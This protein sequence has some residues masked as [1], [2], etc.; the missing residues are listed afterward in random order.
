VNCT[1]V[2]ASRVLATVGTTPQ[3]VVR[4]ISDET[5]VVWIGGGKDWFRKY[6]VMREIFK[7]ALVYSI[8]YGL[9]NDNF[10]NGFIFIMDDIGCADHSWLLRWHYP[11]PH[12]DTLMKYLIEP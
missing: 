3:L 10:E 2:N 5:K 9:F 12:R 1:A 11:T 6:P 4:D 8:G 7:K